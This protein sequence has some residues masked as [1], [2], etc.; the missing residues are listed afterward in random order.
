MLISKKQNKKTLKKTEKTIRKIIKN[1]GISS[2]RGNNMIIKM[3]DIEQRYHG[4][5]GLAHVQLDVP[6]LRSHL[7]TF[8]TFLC[9]K[10]EKN[11]FSIFFID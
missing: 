10:A 5:Q 4:S 1:K 8:R 2:N 11:F 3:F 9:S 6:L 7:E